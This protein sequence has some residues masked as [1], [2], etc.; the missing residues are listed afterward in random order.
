VGNG[1]WIEPANGITQLLGILYPSISGAVC[2]GRALRKRL[3]ARRY[4]N[5]VVGLGK[6]ST[7]P[8]L[9]LKPTPGRI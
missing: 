1:N 6:I 5:A 9:D 8:P 7:S 4:P 2:S 3:A